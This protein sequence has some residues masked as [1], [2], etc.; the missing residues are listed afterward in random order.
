M[1][2]FYHKLFYLTSK[3]ILTF[4]S[5][6]EIIQEQILSTCSV[7]FRRHGSYVVTSPVGLVPITSEKLQH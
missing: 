2:H 3:N 5:F 1:K 6:F 7:L 4:I